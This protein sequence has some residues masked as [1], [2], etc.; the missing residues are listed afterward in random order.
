MSRVDFYILADGDSPEHFA[1]SIAHKA[2]QQ[3]YDIYIHTD[4]KENAA[5]M[6]ELLWTHKDISFLPHSL[7]DAPGHE[8]EAADISS[9]ITIGPGA[10]ALS[11]ISRVRV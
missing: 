6:D 8:A 7:I 5:R 1:C 11:P 2:R 4:S 9:A 3:D 10:G